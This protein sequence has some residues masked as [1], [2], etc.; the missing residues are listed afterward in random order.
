MNYNSIQNFKI[1][2]VKRVYSNKTNVKIPFRKDMACIMS[3]LHQHCT[4]TDFGA[5]L[6]KICWFKVS[7]M[8]DFVR[9]LT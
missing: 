9:R 2:C 7:K 1:P 5:I 4:W 6:N 8:L 3:C